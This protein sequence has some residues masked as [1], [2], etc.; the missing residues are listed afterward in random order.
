MTGHD[1]QENNSSVLLRCEELKEHLEATKDRLNRAALQLEELT[2]VL[3]ARKSYDPISRPWLD[4]LIFPQ[5]IGDVIDAE[6]RMAE[7]RDIA[8]ELGI[9]LPP[10]F[11][12]AG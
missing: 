2:R 6:Q 5:L 8:A 4:E 9:P 10:R 1:V 7:A 11:Y 3:L 12:R